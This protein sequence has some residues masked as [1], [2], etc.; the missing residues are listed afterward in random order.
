MN[1][2]PSVRSWSFPIFEHFFSPARFIYLKPN[3][4]VIT[5]SGTDR[6]RELPY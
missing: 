4:L 3:A 1:G 6:L 2:F 5:S